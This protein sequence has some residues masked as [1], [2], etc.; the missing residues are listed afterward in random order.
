MARLIRSH[1][2]C[3]SEHLARSGQSRVA[4]PS[5]RLNSRLKRSILPVRVSDPANRTPCFR[6]RAR[7]CLTPD[8]GPRN[9]D[10]EKAAWARPPKAPEVPFSNRRNPSRMIHLTA[11]QQMDARATGSP[12]IP[13]CAMG[14]H[15]SGPTR[16]SSKTS[17]V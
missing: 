11:K 14:K 17:L 7:A 2:G 10:N 15:A 5:A 9:P 12:L 16:S 8:R 6:S 13:E 4:G 1:E 3:R